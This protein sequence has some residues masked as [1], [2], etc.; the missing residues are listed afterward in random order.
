MTPTIQVPPLKSLQWD[1]TTRANKKEKLKTNLLP[2][3]M[4]SSTTL[5]LIDDDMMLSG[6][7]MDI[8]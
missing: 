7:E 2:T 3:Q 4:G 5:L 8:G 6:L 1:P